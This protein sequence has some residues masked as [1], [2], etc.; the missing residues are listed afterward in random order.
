MGAGGGADPAVELRRR[1]LE[2]QR[3]ALQRE[4][5]LLLQLS[6]ELAR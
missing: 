5:E 3:K 6:L 2:D 1:Q 4:Y